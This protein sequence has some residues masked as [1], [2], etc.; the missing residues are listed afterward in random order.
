[1]GAKYHT[2]HHT[3][4]RCNYGQVRLSAFRN[5]LTQSRTHSLLP[6]L[7]PLSPPQPT[8]F[9][10]FCDWYWGTLRLPKDKPSSADLQSLEK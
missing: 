4:L 8:Q 5:T 2:I 7:P 1:M 10:I 3:H 9:F 6:S